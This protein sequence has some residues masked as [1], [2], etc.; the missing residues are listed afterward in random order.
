MYTKK[1]SKFEYLHFKVSTFNLS[2]GMTCFNGHPLH[3]RRVGLHIYIVRY[4][5]N[6]YNIINVCIQRSVNVLLLYSFII[7]R[8]TTERVPG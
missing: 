4:N 8:L 6:I 1:N 2:V 5:I 3:Y 7:Y